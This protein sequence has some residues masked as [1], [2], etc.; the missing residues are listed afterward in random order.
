LTLLFPFTAQTGVNVISS[1]EGFG[2]MLRV[3]GFDS[4]VD[5]MGEVR[6]F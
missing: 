4:K 2:Q 6:K 3:S 5:E 1:L